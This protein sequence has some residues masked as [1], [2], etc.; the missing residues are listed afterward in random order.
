MSGKITN[1][2]APSWGF[3]PIF[4]TILFFPFFH[5]SWN[6]NH[7]HG[8]KSQYQYRQWISVSISS[9][10]VAKAISDPILANITELISYQQPQNLISYY[11]YISDRLI[12]ETIMLSIWN[13]RQSIYLYQTHHQT[14]RVDYTKVNVK[15]DRNP[16][17]PTSFA[18][19]FLPK[20]DIIPIC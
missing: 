6:Q 5:Y 2:L 16:R 12:F 9:I 8:L 14:E 19:A 3:L 18:T 1:H 15:H 7:K 13:L 20:G 4:G 11:Q 17:R 10:L